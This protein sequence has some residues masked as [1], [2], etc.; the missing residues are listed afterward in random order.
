MVM[1][2]LNN[3]RQPSVKS[4]FFDAKVS[5]EQLSHAQAQYQT[6]AHPALHPGQT[7]RVYLQGKAIGWLGK[8]H[9]KWQQHYDLS[10][11]TFLFELDVV[12]L[13]NSHVAQYQE[14]SKFLAIRRDIAIVVDETVTVQA[15]LNEVKSAKIPLILDMCLFDVY[16]GKGITESKKSLAFLVLM[17][18]T[19]KTLV[20][21]EVESAMDKL[22]KL[23]E[24]KFG[25]QLR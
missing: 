25:A 17:Q 4:T 7:A 20:D 21:A 13:L 2:C 10:K 22:L 18:D 1:L 14:V 8:L 12:A 9:P 11:N 24:N 23:L 19:Y 15:I 16:Q 3:G 6:E 5:V